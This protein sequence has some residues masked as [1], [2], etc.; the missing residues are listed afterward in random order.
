MGA[1]YTTLP[2]SSCPRLRCSPRVHFSSK[3]FITTASAFVKIPKRHLSTIFHTNIPY[4]ASELSCRITPTKDIPSLQSTS[5]EYFH[6]ECQVYSSLETNKANLPQP[7]SNF[8]ASTYV[9]KSTYSTVKFPPNHIAIVE[10]FK[11]LQMNKLIL[12]SPDPI[13][14]KPTDR[15]T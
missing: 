8:I 9:L 13:R 1:I 2:H 15:L 6:Y 10:Y 4:A 3:V 14:N 11:V 12:C 5:T 7:E